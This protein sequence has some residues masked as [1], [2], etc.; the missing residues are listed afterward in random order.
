MVSEHTDSGLIKF[1]NVGGIDERILPGKTVLVGKD[2]I[3]GVIGAKAIHLQEE[4]N[5]ELIG[6]KEIYI[7]ILVLKKEEAEKFAPLGEYI[8]FNSDFQEFGENCIK[9]KSTG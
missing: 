2:K 9:N 6:S 7:L 1:S 5:S 8:T 4:K 3:P